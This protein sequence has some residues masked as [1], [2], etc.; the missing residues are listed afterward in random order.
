MRV[1]QELVVTSGVLLSLFATACSST[2]GQVAAVADRYLS[3]VAAQDCLTLTRITAPGGSVEPCSELPAR[4]ASLAQKE[5]ISD[6][7]TTVSGRAATATVTLSQDVEITLRLV[8]S[9]TR[10]RVVYP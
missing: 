10:W 9:D 4:A 5:K 6:W 2:D 8:G 7:R 3:A 1:R